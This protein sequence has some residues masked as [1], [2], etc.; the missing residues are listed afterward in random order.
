MDA[1]D[2]W[3]QLLIDFMEDKIIWTRNF[4]NVVFV[5]DNPVEQEH[6]IGNPNEITCKFS[7]IEI[8]CQFQ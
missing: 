4:A 1:K 2:R 5:D 8:T 6:P 3:P 7:S